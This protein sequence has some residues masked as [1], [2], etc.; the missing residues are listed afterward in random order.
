[1]EPADLTVSA[2][3]ARRLAF[4]DTLSWQIRATEGA[5]PA[6]AAEQTQFLTDAYNRIENLADAT[7]FLASAIF[8]GYAHVEKAQNPPGR[9]RPPRSDRTGLLGPEPRSTA[10]PRP[11]DAGRRPTRPGSTTA[12]ARSSWPPPAAS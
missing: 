5:D 10:S 9:A 3:I 4:L 2:A 7:R 12:T 8:R 1:M 6:L 11:T